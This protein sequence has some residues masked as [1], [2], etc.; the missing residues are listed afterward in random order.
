MFRGKLRYQVQNGN[1]G[2]DVGPGYSWHALHRKLSVYL[3]VSRQRTAPGRPEPVVVLLI[4]QCVRLWLSVRVCACV[5]VVYVRVCACV[6]VCACVVVCVCA[7]MCSY[8][9]V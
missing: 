2:P 4:A 5:C 6:C 8:V 7:C 3:L 9:C 1:L